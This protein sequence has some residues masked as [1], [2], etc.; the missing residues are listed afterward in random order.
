MRRQPDSDL[1]RRLITLRNEYAGLALVG[2]NNDETQRLQRL[3]ALGEQERARRG[4]LT[5]EQAEGEKQARRAFQGTQQRDPA[6]PVAAAEP[7]T[8]TARR[9]A[10][11]RRRTTSQD[12]GRDTGRDV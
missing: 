12:A 2:I 5:P 10:H 11:P 4:G 1:D 3:I 7:T 6:G 8:T 9:A